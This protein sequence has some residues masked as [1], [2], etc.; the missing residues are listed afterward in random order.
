MEAIVFADVTDPWAYVGATRFERA[1]ATFTIISG[2]P[3]DIVL[4][5]SLQAGGDVASDPEFLNARV[6]A[7]ALKSGIDLNFADLV[8]A[9]SF[10]AWRLLTW[11]AEFGP[12]T[13]RDLAHQLWR[14]HF[15]EGAD[16]GDPMVLSARAAIVGLDL[17]T[18]EALLASNEY[19]E[20][21][22]AQAEAARSVGVTHLPHVVV[23]TQW[24][25]AG[26]RTQ[27]EYVQ[28][29]HR[30]SVGEAPD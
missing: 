8:P 14:A 20:A 25:L 28:A 6:T 5:A 2:E 13:Q 12:T 9:E 30:I 17:E 11:A 4:R 1:A 22:R 19:G 10:D 23:D 29:L 15:L 3:V 27:N 21:V 26:I 24:A 18:A 16:V 7:A